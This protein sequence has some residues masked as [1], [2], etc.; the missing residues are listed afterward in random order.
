MFSK[1][2][3]GLFNGVVS[4]VQ[5][6]KLIGSDAPKAV[7]HQKWVSLK[8]YRQAQYTLNLV[9]FGDLTEL[10]IFLNV[11]YR[12]K[13]SQ[14]WWSMGFFLVFPYKSGENRGGVFYSK[15]QNSEP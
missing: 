9:K 12:V 5:S 13:R 14:S 10:R 1:G 6:G 7:L 4:Y 3:S 11:V 15:I 2:G 8:W